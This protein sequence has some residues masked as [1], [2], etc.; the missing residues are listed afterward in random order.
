[1][2]SE[3]REPGRLSRSRGRAARRTLDFDDNKYALGGNKYTSYK[4]ETNLYSMT[5]DN[6]C[7]EQYEISDDERD[8]YCDYENQDD[9]ECLKQLKNQDKYKYVNTRRRPQYFKK[10]P[11]SKLRLTLNSEVDQQPTP[12]NQSNEFVLKQYKI[13]IERDSKVEGCYDVDTA[14]GNIKMSYRK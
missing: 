14:Q 12:E 6:S 8:R 2:D 13:P 3:C 5:A 9:D 7:D 11:D 10:V 4:I 1:M